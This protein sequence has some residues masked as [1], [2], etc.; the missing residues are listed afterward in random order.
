MPEGNIESQVVEHKDL[1]GRSF[2][3]EELKEAHILGV[4]DK[5]DGR[6]A[7]GTQCGDADE[8]AFVA[9]MNGY[10]GFDLDV[11]ALVTRMQEVE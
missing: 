3:D 4:S 6:R 2:T 11:P 7:S 8:A 10:H 5:R 9:Y 1:F